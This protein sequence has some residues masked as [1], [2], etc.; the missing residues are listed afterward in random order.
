MESESSS[1]E[2]SSSEEEV[3]ITSRREL[4]AII[5]KLLSCKFDIFDI[6][7]IVKGGCRGKSVYL[8]RRDVSYLCQKCK[9]IFLEDPMLLELKAPIKV[10][11]I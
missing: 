10:C 5:K 4:D 3:I 1:S 6:Y 7:L 9:K 8:S 2:S 11:G